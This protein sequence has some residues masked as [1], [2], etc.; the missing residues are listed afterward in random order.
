[1][2]PAAVHRYKHG[3]TSHIP[4]LSHSCP[5]LSFH[6]MAAEGTERRDTGAF[7]QGFCWGGRRVRNGCL[8]AKQD[9]IGL[10]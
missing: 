9:G 10:R 6:Q 4:D 1:M 8:G 5:T 7:Q 2:R 3:A